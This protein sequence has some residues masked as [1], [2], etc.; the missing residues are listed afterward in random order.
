MCWEIVRRRPKVNVCTEATR[1]RRST[2]TI[3]W[4]RQLGLSP[5]GAAPIP[6]ARRSIGL[7]SLL[8]A[9][10]AASGRG[11]R[12]EHAELVS[13]GI[14]QDG[15]GLV[16]LAN[17]RQVS[18]QRQ[19]TT[20]LGIPV[21]RTK[22]EMEAILHRLAFWYTHEEKARQSVGRGPNL[23]LVAR[24]VHDDPS[25]G[26]LPPAPERHWIVCI[27]AR[28]FP[29]QAHETSVYVSPV[30]VKLVD[31]PRRTGAIAEQRSFRNRRCAKLE[32]RPREGLLHP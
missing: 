25:E 12:T 28:L 2:P 8:S 15:P 14:G 32:V 6:V 21:S 16:A 22:V 7:R 9:S 30:H 18:T 19:Q 5:G 4:N 27:N 3:D 31:S 29:L 23:E 20:D 11:P 24:L 17:V 1:V 26:L 13:F 10:H